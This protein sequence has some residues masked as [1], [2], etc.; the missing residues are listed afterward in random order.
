MAEIEGHLQRIRAGSH[1]LWVDD[2]P[3][4][5]VDEV[6][7]LREMGLG[8]DV[9]QSNQAAVHAFRQRRYD[10]VISD[11]HRDPPEDGD[12]WPGLR[13]PAAL[14]R[15]YPDMP[16]PPFIFYVHQVDAPMTDMGHPVVRTPT[17]LLDQIELALRDGG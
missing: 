3:R 12:Q 7:M 1:V 4:N 9:R 2:N 15:E 6:M 11:I 16:L 13:L 10:L 17:E 5:N 14:E 8:V